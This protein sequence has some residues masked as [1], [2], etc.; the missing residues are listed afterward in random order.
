MRALSRFDHTS[1][2]YNA[3]HV[4]MTTVPRVLSRQD[5]GTDVG[6]LSKIQEDLNV[7]TSLRGDVH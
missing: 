3:T 2:F 5:R 7:K 6:A 1:A 4:R